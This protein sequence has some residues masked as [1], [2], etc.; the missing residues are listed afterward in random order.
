MSRPA[1]QP[2]A[3][4]GTRV[5]R[6]GGVTV[7]APRGS[8]TGEAAASFAELLAEEEVRTLGRLVVDLSGVA[9]LDSIGL[10][11]LVDAAG[12]LEDGGLTLRLCGATSA[13]ATILEIT[14]Q[15]EAFDHHD[16]AEDAARSFL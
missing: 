10:E 7:L 2:E 11:S 12:R 8:L 6:I 4:A 5:Q 13:I 15:H 14:G 3:P 16:D 9:A 1:E